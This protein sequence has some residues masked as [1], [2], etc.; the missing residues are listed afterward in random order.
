MIRFFFLF[1]FLACSFS[2]QSQSVKKAYKL[3]EKG[4]LLKFEE[5]L[6]KMDEK[7][8]ESS[9]KYFLYSL[10][11]LENLESRSSID[12]SYLL[13]NKSKETYPNEFPKEREELEELGINLLSI[14]S[15]IAVID[16]I[17]FD[18][19]KEENT[20]KEYKKY[21]VDH[22]ESKFYD[23]SK[24]NWHTLEF[25]I[26]SNINTWQA[27]EEFMNEFPNANDF[28]LAKSLYEELLFKEK[29]SDRSLISFEKFLND[30]PKTPYRDSLE[31][32]IFKYYGLSNNVDNL[33]RFVEKYPESKFITEAVNIIYHSSDRD[34][35]S[36]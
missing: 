7:S 11:Y 13:I 23:Q 32:M 35:L 17:E 4:D 9:G 16:S 33:K 8:I 24:K 29:T 2:L 30:N 34:L 1:T 25:K 20:I 12:S 15:I 10:L 27:Y 19:V 6:E 36:L 5:T 21:M 3:Y 31:F 14:D 28:S 22:K 26:V 18:F